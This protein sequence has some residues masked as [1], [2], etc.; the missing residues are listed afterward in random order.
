MDRGVP[1]RVKTFLGLVV[2]N[3]RVAN[4]PSI[5]DVF[6]LERESGQG[7]VSATL[8]VAASLAPELQARAVAL[9]GL[10]AHWTIGS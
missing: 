3:S 7:S 10:E 4:L 1:D 8:T 9:V 2:D 5:A 6:H